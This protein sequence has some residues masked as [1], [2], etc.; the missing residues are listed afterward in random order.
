MKRTRVVKLLKKAG[1]KET[2]G[3]RHD[4]FMKKGF[5]P[6]SAPRHNEISKGTALKIL[7]IAE[8]DVQ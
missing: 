2:H 6:I 8:I 3:G 1:Y 7:K 5:P 4:L